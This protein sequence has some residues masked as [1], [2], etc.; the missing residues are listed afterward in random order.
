V[1]SEEMGAPSV[2]MM[3]PSATAAPLFAGSYL[4]AWALVGL[5]IVA[6]GVAIAAT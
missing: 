3:L 4:G 2:P 6:V 5:A 1:T